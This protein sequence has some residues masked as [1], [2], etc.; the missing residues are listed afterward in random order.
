MIKLSEIQ[1]RVFSIELP[2][3]KVKKWDIIDLAKI[4]APYMAQEEEDNVNAV[5][6]IQKIW[7]IPGLPGSVAVQLVGEFMVEYSNAMEDIG[8]NIKKKLGEKLLKS[9]DSTPVVLD[10]PVN[11]AQKTD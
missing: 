6:E 10:T 8:D 3:G 5:D 1:E 9:Q 7:D 2:N 11:S 4:L